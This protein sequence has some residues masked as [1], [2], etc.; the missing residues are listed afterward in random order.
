MSKTVRARSA[1]AATVSLAALVAAY[2][3][4]AQE[5]AQTPAEAASTPAAGGVPE[6]AV[7]RGIPTIVVTAQRRAESLQD[8]P[9]AVSAFSDESLAAQQIENTLDLQQALPNTTFTG[10]NFGGANITIRGIGSPVVAASGDAGVGVHINDMPLLGSGGLFDTEFFDIERIEVLRGPQGTLFGRNATGGV[11]NLITAKPDLSGFGASGEVQ[12]GNYNALSTRGM[13][14]V[15]LGDAVGVR[16]AGLYLNRDGFTDN[17]FTGDDIDGR[18]NYS[19]RGTIGFEPTSN[20]S[21]YVTVQY[22]KEDSS[23]ARNQK[24][25]CA[26]DPTGVLGCRPDRL[27]TQPVNGNATLATILSSAEFLTVAASP[28]LAP[29]ALGSL[30]GPNPFADTVTPENLRAVSIDFEPT[31]ESEY[32][33]AQGELEHDFGN[34]TA[35]LNGGYSTAKTDS[36]GDYNLNVTSSVLPQIAQLQAFA[37]ITD[38]ANP[39]FPLA[40]IAQGILATPLFQNGQ[41]CVSDANRDYVGFIGGDIYGCADNTTEYDRDTDDVEQWS[42]EARIASD[43]DGP[44]NFLLGG[45][46][47]H[48][49]VDTNYYVAASGLDYANLLLGGPASG[50]AAATGP[51]TFSSETND[52]ELDS[53]GLFGEAYVDFTDELSLTLGLRYSKD[54][55]SVAD[56]QLLANVPIPFGTT[57]LTP[58]LLEAGGYDADPDTPGL[59]T[60][61]RSEA[62]FEEV[63]GRALLSWNPYTSF[64]DDTLVYASFSRGYKPGGIN[65]PFDSSLFNAPQTFDSEIIKA[66]EIGTKNTFGG[67]VAVINLT[68]FYYDYSDFQVSRIFNRTSFNDNTDA[69]IYGVELE[70]VFNPTDALTINLTGSYQKTEI[71]D[72]VVQ[73]TRDPSGGRSNAVIIKDIT[74]ASNCVFTSDT[75]DQATLGALVSGF[76]S[77][78]GLQGAVPVPG[79]QALGAY[80]ICSALAGAAAT[81]ELGPASDLISLDVLN[82]GTPILPDGVP[83]DLS[84]NELLNSPNWK[85]SVGAQYEIDLA[86]GWVLTPRADLNFVGNAFA[87]NY[88]RPVDKIGA[89]EIVN[90]QLTLTSPDDRF[91]V[92]G[93]ITNAFD[94]EAQTGRYVTDQ[95]S[96]LFTNIYLTEPQRYG[97]A[98]GFRF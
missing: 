74:T 14:N 62:S 67:G 18:D 45:I 96:G 13:V 36:Y 93:F 12:Y 61:R 50:F 82:D 66:F 30:Y 56:R 41:I 38:P 95:S 23:R 48:A 71:K 24:Q 78:L 88:N 60:F 6:A 76:N 42:A 44:F 29:F 73:D 69:E 92:R 57:T 34:L 81:G 49:K 83:F 26:T 22:Q 37:S 35:T 2:P 52:Y 27:D 59:Q 84:G 87:T 64:S 4:A 94:V 54:D 47:L 11:I 28:A 19:L 70:S 86:G 89:Y 17:L 53:Y 80:S 10:G 8:V 97:A 63:T 51:T 75:L 85:F 77:A 21:G 46:Y 40:G 25:L 32:F 15:P 79:T 5:V 31:Y 55:K 16:L 72:L 58:E 98:V 7:T 33:V 39:A 90:A 68:A 65:P 1:F 20:T 43:F 91:Y 3:A 9:V